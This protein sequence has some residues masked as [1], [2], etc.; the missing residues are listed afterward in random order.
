VTIIRIYIAYANLA[1]SKYDRYYS[2]W[3]IKRASYSYERRRTFDIGLVC[4]MICNQ[5]DQPDTRKSPQEIW[6]VTR[7]SRRLLQRIIVWLDLQHKTSNENW[8]ISIYFPPWFRIYLLIGLWLWTHLFI[9]RQKQIDRQTDIYKWKHNIQPS[10]HQSN[11]TSV[12]RYTSI[13]IRRHCSQVSKK[14]AKERYS[15]DI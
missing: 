11:Y 10:S 6:R 5:E 12:P 3:R 8:N 9:Q 2:G 13:I 1:F 14:L 4:E 7:I 15:I